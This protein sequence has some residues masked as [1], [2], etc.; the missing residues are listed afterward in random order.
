MFGTAVPTQFTR[1][2]SDSGEIRFLLN[3]VANQQ[4]A[5][6]DYIRRLVQ[7]RFVYL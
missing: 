7:V 1:L 3:D 2:P 4:P 5:A 6:V